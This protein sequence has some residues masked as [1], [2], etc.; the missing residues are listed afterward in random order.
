MPKFYYDGDTFTRGA[1]VFRV[2]FSHDH[3]AGTPWDNCE[4]VGDVSAWTTRD[5]R[6]GERVLASD[7]SSKRFYD[8]AGAMRRARAEGW[9]AAP[10]D[11]GTKG[12]RAARAV[13][14]DFERLRTWCADLWHYVGVTVELLDADCNG[15]GDAESLW[16]VESDDHAG[17]IEVAHDLADQIAAHLAR[18]AEDGAA[19]ASARA[20]MID[21]HAV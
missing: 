4:G 13:E 21:A 19:I 2:T 11:K 10:H 8:F 12:Q 18:L 9:S 3:D 20:A 15:T 7:R 17:Q 6:P 16:S 14:R 5:K 1:H